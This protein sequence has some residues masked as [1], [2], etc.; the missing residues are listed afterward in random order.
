MITVEQAKKIA[1]VQMEPLGDYWRKNVPGDELVLAATFEFNEGWLF[2][3]TSQKFLQSKNNADRPIGVGP[4]IV[5]KENG[6]FMLMGSGN[7]Q[8]EYMSEFR[9]YL[10]KKGRR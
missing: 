5:S 2:Y 7:T 1:L 8:E 3:F 6:Q 4:V 9:E 10:Q